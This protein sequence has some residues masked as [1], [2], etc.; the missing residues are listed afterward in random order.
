MTGSVALDV[1]IGLIFIYLLFSLF[2]TIIMEIIN[3]LLGLRARNL[4]YALRRML[5]DEK[6]HQLFPVKK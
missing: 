2:G 3:S 5:M 6:E 4:R 1:V